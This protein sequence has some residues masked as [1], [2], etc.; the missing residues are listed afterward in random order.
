ME[1]TLAKQ[2]YLLLSFKYRGIS[3]NAILQSLN[4]FINIFSTCQYWIAPVL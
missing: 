4:L 3:K 1:L 2:K